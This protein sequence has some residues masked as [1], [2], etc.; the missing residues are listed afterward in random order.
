MQRFKEDSKGISYAISFTLG[1]IIVSMIVVNVFLHNFD[2]NQLDYERS[3]ENIKIVNVSSLNSSS[4]FVAQN[5]YNVSIGSHISGSYIDTGQIDNQY[6]QFIEGGGRFKLHIDGI[7]S[8]DVSNY[9]LTEI[10]TVEIQLRYRAFDSGENWFLQAY[11][12]T[13]NEY[14]DFGFNSTAG[15]APTSN[16]SNYTVNLTVQWNSYVDENGTVLVRIADEGP[17]SVR[18]IIDIDFL[19]VKII[20]P[21]IHITLQNRGS[22]TSQLVSLWVNDSTLHRRYDINI[23]INSG[24]T[25][26]YIYSN[27]TLPQKPYTV[28]VVTH[29][30]NIAI[31]SV[32]ED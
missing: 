14:S 20:I 27:M 18:T 22:L 12:W 16:W 32:N 23:F 8:V 19:A 13:S 30:G 28:K 10:E 31:L 24:E 17:D 29:R 5:E 2:M 21:G 26:S 1:L 25:I 6:E 15:H 4:W 7:F 9:P 11:N 3:Q